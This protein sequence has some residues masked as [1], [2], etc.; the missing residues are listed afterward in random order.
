MAESR[1]STGTVKWFNSQKGFGFITPQDGTDDLFVHFT[2]IR[3]DGYRSLS[4]GQSVEFLLD[5]GDD[6]RTMAVDVTSA[7]RSRRPGGFRGGGGRGRGGG[8]GG[9]FGRRGGGPECYNC[10]RIGHLARDCYHGQGGGGGVDGDG[11]NRR[12]G[13][14][15]GGGG[16]GCFNCGEEGHFVRECPDVGERK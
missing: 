16:R 12:R 3:S 8:R 9:G 10:G 1:R 7:V 5:Y 15:G 6:G 2:S 14:G 11:R 4:E 13:G